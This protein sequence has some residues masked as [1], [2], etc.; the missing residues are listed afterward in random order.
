[1]SEN[2]QM[3]KINSY[4]KYQK[5]I[6]K[7]I[8]KEL[9]ANTPFKYEKTNSNHLKVCVDGLEKPIYTSCTPSDR[10]SGDNFMGDLRC[11]L[12]AAHV[13]RQPKIIVSKKMN[14]LQVKAQYVENLMAAC[15]KTVRTNIQQYSEKEQ[16]WVI[17]E[18][19]IQALKAQRKSLAGRIFE[20]A[21]KV[22]RNQQYITGAD[23]NIIRGEILK[24]LSYMLPNIADYANTLKPKRVRSE[25]SK[26]VSAETGS[27]ILPNVEAANERGDD[28][29]QTAENVR[30]K[31]LKKHSTK[32]NEVGIQSASSNINPAEAL[33]A[34][35][36]AQAIQNLRRLSRNESEA[37]LEYI[38]IAMAENHQQDLQEVLSMMASKGITLNMLSDYSENAA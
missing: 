11:A 31:G 4:S 37:M 25:L 33:A 22:H 14:I 7:K 5:E 16:S 26:A 34:M 32:K 10:K 38:Q 9:G 19:S 20:Q 28:L 17:K 1:M 13:K 24:H 21:Q 35:N 36:K 29:K 30:L 12:K 6:I 2:N 3:H 27:I 23:S 18:G 8:G 15:I